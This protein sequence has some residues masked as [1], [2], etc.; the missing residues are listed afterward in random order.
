MYEVPR[1]SFLSS[2]RNYCVLE[3]KEHATA[4]LIALDEVHPPNERRKQE[5]QSKAIVR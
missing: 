1:L 3:P 2:G 4:V 5:G